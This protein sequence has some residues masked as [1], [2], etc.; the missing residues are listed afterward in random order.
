CDV[1]LAAGL[2]LEDAGGQPGRRALR[3]LLG[4]LALLLA[5]PAAEL[6]RA[7]RGLDGE[8]LLLAAL[9]VVGRDRHELRPDVAAEA[10]LADRVP[11]GLEGELEQ[12]QD[13]RV[14]VQVRVGVA[15]EDPQ[16]LL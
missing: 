2:V 14:R 1:V 4:L 5:R 9:E 8:E 15:P 13:G 11:G 12:A 6:A 16:Q 10:D 3:A 7:G